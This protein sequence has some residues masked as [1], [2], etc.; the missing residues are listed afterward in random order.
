MRKRLT[1]MTLESKPPTTG[2]IEVRDTD[3]SLVFRLTA[4]GGRSFSVRTRLWGKQIRVNYPGAATIDELAAARTWAIDTVAKAGRGEDPRIAEKPLASG[5]DNF[6]TLVDRFI[7][8]YAKRHNKSWA[9]T[10]RIFRAY[11]SPRWG[12]R[13][14]ATIGRLDVTELLDDLEDNRGVYTANRTLA[15]I[16]K[17]FNWH[18]ARDDTFVSPIVQGM[19][20]KGEA[21]RSRVLTDDEIK[22]L[23]G[24]WDELGWPWGDYH[25]I[26]LL[27]MQRK[28]EVANIRRSHIHDGIWILPSE[29]TKANRAH[30][31]PL[32]SIA[33]DVLGGLPKFKDI[34]LYFISGRKG[35][36]PLAGFGRAKNQSDRLS[37][38][39]GWRLHDL[40]RS[41]G[42]WMRRTHVDLTIRKAIFNHSLRSVEGVTGVYAGNDPHAF[43]EPKRR[44]LESWA[45]HILQIVEG[46]VEEN[47]IPIRVVE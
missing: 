1:K 32:A 35:D 33:S 16:R 10:Q 37:G 30:T 6:D 8:R 43:D 22:A 29:L 15:A 28:M 21:Q 36:S 5:A 12:D 38:V 26:L 23:W 14:V 2:R 17:L 4:K 42:D 31:V 40:R 24:T 3:S 34:D 39:T 13:P 27:T 18:A 9:E 7:E 41:G 25:K 11:V 47:V 45:T 46:T 44:V 20:R 19:A